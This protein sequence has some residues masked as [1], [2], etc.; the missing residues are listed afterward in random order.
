MLVNNIITISF[1]TCFDKK[2][3]NN[4]IE[5]LHNYFQL[6]KGKIFPIKI[7]KIQECKKNNILV[8]KN[9]TYEQI[10]N[11]SMFELGENKIKYLL[12]YKNDQAVLYY[13]YPVFQWLHKKLN[14]G[15]TIKS[16]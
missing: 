16:I 15:W 4:D 14:L 2:N 6:Y 11:I 3:Y 1:D 12:K 10:Q 9:I 7:F 5:I 13:D 8:I